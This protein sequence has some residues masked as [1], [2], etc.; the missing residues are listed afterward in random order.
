MVCD[1]EGNPVQNVDLTAYSVTKKFEYS[2]PSVPYL[3]AQ[4]KNKTVINN[5]TINEHLFNNFPG[6]GL[7][8]NHWRLLAG[9]DTIE[10]YKF[11]YPGNDIYRFQYPSELTQFAPFV[12][13]GGQPVPIHVIYVDKKPIYFSWSTNI[14]PYSFPVDSGYHYIKLRTTNRIIE[15][16][17]VYFGFHTKTII[18]LRDSIINKKAYVNKLES[19]LSDFEKDN[20]Y[21]Y[22]FPYRYQFGEYFGY[23]EQNGKVYFLKPG[24][25]NPNNNLTGPVDPIGTKFQFV[26]SLSLKFTHEPLFEYEFAPGLLKMRSVDPKTRYPDYLYNYNVRESLTDKVLK[27]ADIIENWKDYINQKRYL[28]ARYNYPKTTS[29]GM[30]TMKIDLVADSIKSSIRPL[31]ILLFRYDESNFL[32][33][34]PGSNF[35]FN[36]LDEGYYKI[37]FFLPGSEYSVIDSLYVSPNGIN[38][39]KIKLPQK[40][41]KDA[42][43]TSVSKIIEENIFKPV[44]V[45]QT[46]ETETKQIYNKY[47]QEFRFTGVGDIIEGYIHDEDGSPIPG[48][49]VMVKGTTFGTISNLDGYY[50][51]NVP[52]GNN[53][54]SFSFI[55]YQQK[56]IDISDKKILNV[57]LTPEV[58]NLQ[59]VVVVGYGVQRKSSLTGSIAVVNTTRDTGSTIIFC[60]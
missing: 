30:G 25:A 57:N 33:I 7:D 9:L 10:Y 40:H 13:S 52:R 15:I 29:R 38:F 55:G 2:P 1:Q 32:R 41:I 8:Y 39:H 44:S 19:H 6:L 60:K 20:L 11:I 47:Q 23:I 4:R 46:Q 58:L 37:L 49:T 53:V 16:D 34:Y 51:L 28:T 17:S 24:M 12:I 27:S 59:E 56:E 5:F 3:G 50:S 36:D 54:L 31:N 26:D 42:F 48:V 14:Q 18:S 43:S 45:S 21:K 35:T 22:I